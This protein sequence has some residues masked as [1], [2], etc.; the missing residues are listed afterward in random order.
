MVFHLNFIASF[1]YKGGWTKGDLHFEAIRL[2][3]WDM[4]EENNFNSKIELPIDIIGLKSWFPT[5]YKII[6]IWLYSKKVCMC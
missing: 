6:A 4:V 1:I 2:V 3:S 5:C